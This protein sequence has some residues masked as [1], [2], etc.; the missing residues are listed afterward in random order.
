M[1]RRHTDPGARAIIVGTLLSLFS[2]SCSAVSVEQP[3][4]YT[5]Q[6]LRIESSDVTLPHVLRVSDFDVA[7]HLTGERLVAQL[8][9]ARVAPREQ[10]RWSA[11]LSAL[12]TSSIG[13]GLLEAR[14]FR[15]VVDNRDAAPADLVLE[16]RILG[17]EEDH[18]GPVRQAHVALALILRGEVGGEILLQERVAA[19]V[20]LSRE[21]GET[22]VRG[23]HEALGLAF[24]NFLRSAEKTA[25]AWSAPHHD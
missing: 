25:S 3:S 11:P 16:G 9:T 18:Q 13:A 24:R 5:L 6:A 19:K 12:V 20:P 17:F 7:P 2:L 14:R 4:F 22:L 15:A 8:R 21:D 1:T 10:E 23:L